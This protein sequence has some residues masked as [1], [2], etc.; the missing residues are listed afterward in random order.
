MRI[1]ATNDSSA[2]QGARIRF[3]GRATSFSAVMNEA[4]EKYSGQVDFTRMTRQELIDWMNGQL[5]SGKMT[6]EESWPFLVMTLAGENAPEGTR[7]DYLQLTRGAIQG[8]SSRK[9]EANL[10]IF[11]FA[12]QIMQERR[13]ESG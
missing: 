7:Y 8:A 6:M 1:D 2:G 12:L 4:M 13:S 5:R 10:K 11:E 9:D 3:N